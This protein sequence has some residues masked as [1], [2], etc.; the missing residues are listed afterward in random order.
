[1]TVKFEGFCSGVLRGVWIALLLVMVPAMA[2]RQTVTTTNDSLAGSFRYAVTQAAPGDTVC[3]NV[4]AVDSQIGPSTQ[5]VIDKDIVVLGRNS[6]NNKRMTIN[7]RWGVFAIRAGKVCISNLSL[8]NSFGSINKGGVVFISG[9]NTEVRMDSMEIMGGDITGFGGGIY[10]SF[11]NVKLN[12]CTIHYNGRSPDC[13]TGLGRG[14]GIYNYCG[15]FII[16]NSIITRNTAGGGGG[17]YNAYGTM[18][19]SNST[20]SNN[21]AYIGGSNF[22][23]TYGGGIANY[24]GNLVIFNSTITNNTCTSYPTWTLVYAS[25]KAFGGGVCNLL[26][27]L[28]IVNSTVCYNTCFGSCGLNSCYGISRG[29]GLYTGNGG[30]IDDREA[31]G[32]LINTTIFGDTCRNQDGL[33]Y[34]GGL[35]VSDRSYGINNIMINNSGGDGIA[36]AGCKNLTGDIL[37][38]WWGGSI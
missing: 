7:S 22:G 3:F 2:G 35:S 14:G 1:M 6:S 12:A 37:I 15:N 23:S 26:G 27:L 25:A 13:C 38:L 33:C 28:A 17:I 9:E 21:T 4:P 20:I 36:Q 18:T 5:I 29:G 8:W 19:I 11:A 34:S 30:C 10:D 24:L 31:I 16:T 32:C